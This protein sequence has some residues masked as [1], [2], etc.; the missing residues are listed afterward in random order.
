MKKTICSLCVVASLFIAGC[1][2][3][4]IIDPNNFD[5]MKL[6]PAEKTMITS[7][8]NQVKNN[9]NCYSTDFFIQYQGLKYVLVS[10]NNVPVGKEPF[11]DIAM[12]IA[13]ID[14]NRKSSLC[15]ETSLSDYY[16]TARGISLSQ[17]NTSNSFASAKKSDVINDNVETYELS[18]SLYSDLILAVKDCKRANIKVQGKFEPYQKLTKENYDWVVGVIQDCNKFRLE[19]A[20][21]K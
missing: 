17:C 7:W 6:T 16:Y 5:N 1:D 11:C 15:T 20:L 8:A 2:Q 18:T 14:K 19:E 13:A 3:P 9:G 10:R 21:N 4:Y 12:D